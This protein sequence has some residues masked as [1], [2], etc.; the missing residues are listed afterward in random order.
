MLSDTNA[1]ALN[2]IARG[3]CDAGW[4]VKALRMLPHS[5][6]VHTEQ[7]AEMYAV[8]YLLGYLPLHDKQQCNTGCTHTIP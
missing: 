7:E 3:L 1:A 8:L 2:A 4:G 5:K 6:Y